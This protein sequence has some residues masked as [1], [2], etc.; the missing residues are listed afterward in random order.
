MPDVRL[1]VHRKDGPVAGLLDILMAASIHHLAALRGDL[2]KALVLQPEALIDRSLAA[3]RFRHL[4]LLFDK[5]FAV[6]LVSI[7]LRSCFLVL[8]GK[9][10]M[11][12]DWLLVGLLLLSGPPLVLKLKLLLRVTLL[13]LKL[14]NLRLVVLDASV[15]QSLVLSFLLFQKFLLMLSRCRL[16]LLKRLFLGLM[17]QV[18]LF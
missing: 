4:P 13:L 5:P 7:T 14:V 17:L 3:L 2:A 12:D 8:D 10:T 16:L 18:L 15:F 1:I 11:H 6:R 9:L